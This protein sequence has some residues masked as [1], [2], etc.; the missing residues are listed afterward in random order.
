M[1]V[2]DFQGVM[3]CLAEFYTQEIDILHAY[4]ENIDGEVCRS[5]EPVLDPCTGKPLVNVRS[6]FKHN[7]MRYG[8]NGQRIVET[9]T[10]TIDVPCVIE[11]VSTRNRVRYG[12]CEWHVENV[13]IDLDV[14]MRLQVKKVED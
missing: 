9:D 5:W 10:A 8:E 12:G 14:A 11:C 7:A 2:I 1:A 6:Q 3:D 4:E 13:I